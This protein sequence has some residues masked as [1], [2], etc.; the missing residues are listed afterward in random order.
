MGSPSHQQ[1]TNPIGVNHAVIL[2]VFAC[3][4]ELKPMFYDISSTI[5][6]TDDNGVRTD[7]EDVEFVSVFN[8]KITTPK[9]LGKCILSNVRSSILIMGLLSFQ[10]GRRVLWTRCFDRH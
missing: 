6:V 5:I 10:L 1:S 4:P 8:Q 7:M 9:P 2:T 3:N